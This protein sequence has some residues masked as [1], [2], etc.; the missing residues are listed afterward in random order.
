MKGELRYSRLAPLFLNAY[1][2]L[3]L[4]RLCIAALLRLEGGEL[5]SGT[6]RQILASW[7]G[8]CVGAYSYGHCMIPTAFPSGVTVGRY[9]S[10]GPGVQVFLRNHP[11]DRLS[12]HPF[13]YLSRLGFVTEDTI[14][15]GVLEIGHD[16]WIGASAIITSGCARIGIGAIVGAGAVVTRDVPDFAIVAGNPA[17]LIR[18]RFST[19]TCE[20]IIASRWWELSV[21]DCV[22][23]LDDMV[24]PL[25]AEPT[26]H[27]LLSSVGSVARRGDQF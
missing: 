23:C 7:H 21:A 20:A 8:V 26:R 27:P 24:K 11:L 14:P 3:H 12:Q 16:A 1:R 19:E 6:L 18:S 10:V 4:R 17:K 9:V 22:R 25:C 13:F 2:K 5:Y 15:V